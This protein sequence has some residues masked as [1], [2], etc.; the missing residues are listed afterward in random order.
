MNLLIEYYKPQNDMRDS[1]Y[2]FCIQQNISLKGIKKI[3]VFISDDSSFEVTN[4]KVEVIKSTKRPTFYDLMDYCNKNLSGDICAIANTDIFFDESLDNLQTFD[5]DN[6]F[7]ALTRWDMLQENNSWKIRYYEFPWRNP[8][9]TIL[10]SY[11]SQDA[12]IFKS[13][14]KLDS[15]CDFLMGKP[16]CDNRISQILHEN[17]YDVRNPSRLIIIKHLHLSG[18]R[19]Y[20]NQE[21][22][23]G[24]YLLIKPTD[25]LD[26][27]T[28]KFTIPHF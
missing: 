28:E 26:S 2:L 16:G 25:K 7:L 12:W 14:I 22:V 15:R 13:P 20:N 11:F 19:T 23:P 6:T 5:F 3:F 9:D 4:E 17:N 8:N 1:E 27:K 18:Y 21:I 24:P 10:T